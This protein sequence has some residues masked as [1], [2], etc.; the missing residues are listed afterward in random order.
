MQKKDDGNPCGILFGIAFAALLVY[1]AFNIGQSIL[2]FLKVAGMCLGAAVLALGLFIVIS[3]ISNRLIRKSRYFSLRC[4]PVE[5]EIPAAL[6][7]PADLPEAPG[8]E[9]IQPLYL[10][11]SLT[12][13]GLRLAPHPPRPGWKWFP[14]DNAPRFNSLGGQPPEFVVIPP[15][16][17]SLYYRPLSRRENRSILNAPA[18]AP[19]FSG[20]LPD[21]WGTQPMEIILIYTSICD[22]KRLNLNIPRT[23]PL[24]LCLVVLDEKGWEDSAATIK[25]YREI[26]STKKPVESSNDD[27]DSWMYRS[28]PTMPW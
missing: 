13:Y 11:A 1:I 7:I 28:R 15:Y 18:D 22:P 19:N 17:F 2:D 8:Q 20:D 16:A 4:Y 21:S 3:L 9:S 25:F 10:L 5:M 23:N 24:K 12:N 6:P 26:W 27:D 14:A